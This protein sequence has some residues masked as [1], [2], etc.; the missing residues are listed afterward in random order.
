VTRAGGHEAEK[1]G[2]M[3]RLRRQVTG[4]LCRL[5]IALLLMLLVASPGLASTAVIEASAPLQD[6]SERS[7]TL[8]INS[9]AETAAE[10][11]V[12]IGLRWIHDARALVLT[13]LVI[14][15]I[16]VSDMK[17]EGEEE[18]EEV[19]TEWGGR[20]GAGSDP[21]RRFDL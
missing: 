1:E 15:Q 10:H 8:A 3:L 17:P 12:A 7:I 5:A 18:E 13:E 6:H 11:A 21:L 9:A 19:E 14:V 4:F 2:K 16:L 20:S